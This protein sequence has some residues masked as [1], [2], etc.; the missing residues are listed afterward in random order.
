MTEINHLLK[1][2]CQLTITESL[3]L[4]QYHDKF[5]WKF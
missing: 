4:N 5:L 1:F 2:F 3:A